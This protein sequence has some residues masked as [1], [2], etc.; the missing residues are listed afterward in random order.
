MVLK[1]AVMAL[2]VG[3]ILQWLCLLQIRMEISELRKR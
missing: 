3:G 1:I 2:L